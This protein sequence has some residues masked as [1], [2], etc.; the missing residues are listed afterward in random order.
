M[1]KFKRALLFF[2]LGLMAF[3]LGLNYYLRPFEKHF[4]A[5]IEERKRLEELAKAELEK[6]EDKSEVVIDPLAEL[7]QREKISLLFAIPLNINIEADTEKQ[8]WSQQITFLK[9]N[10]ITPLFITVFGKDIDKKQVEATRDDI[11]KTFSDSKYLPRIAV[12]HEGGSV[13]RLAGDGF[14]KL[15]SWQKFCALDDIKRQELLAS[16]ASELKNS[17]IDVIF[18]PVLDVGKSSVLKD[19]ICDTESYATVARRSEELI[20]AYNKAGIM[21]VIKHFPGIGLAKN[22]LHEDFDRIEVQENDVKLYKYIIDNVDKVGVM[23]SHAGVTNQD[24]DV[25]CSLSSFCIGEFKSAY[26]TVPVFSDALEMKAAFYDKNDS[27]KTQIQVVK[28][29]IIAG[30]EIL[31]FGDSLSAEDFAKIILELESIYK[32]DEE[33][34]KIVDNSVRKNLSIAKKN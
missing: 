27:D 2:L 16:S 23:V 31:V 26:K 32:S 10:D 29:A 22:D 11:K 24:K 14:T 15:P 21:P 18:A 1:Q 33:F 7:S 6:K 9:N 30:N 12:D 17:G 19:R 8:D 25:P 20:K 5:Q 13:Q 4:N 28:E 34:R 3:L